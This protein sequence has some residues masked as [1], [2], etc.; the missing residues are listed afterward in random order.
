MLRLTRKVYLFPGKSY[1]GTWGT[2]CGTKL[3]DNNSR[4]VFTVMNYLA[5]YSSSNGQRFFSK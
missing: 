3:K 5:K 1:L 2:N 4:H